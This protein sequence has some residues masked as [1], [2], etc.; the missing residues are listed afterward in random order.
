MSLHWTLQRSNRLER[1]IHLRPHPRPVAPGEN[2]AVLVQ[3]WVVEG[4]SLLT[5]GPAT[6]SSVVPEERRRVGC[7][8]YLKEPRRLARCGGGPV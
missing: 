5:R 7:S 3:L 4:V 2:M 6:P 8:A 1:M